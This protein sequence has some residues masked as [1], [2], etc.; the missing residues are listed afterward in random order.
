MRS[1]DGALTERLHEWKPSGKRGA[2]RKRRMWYN[3][4]VSL[5][6]DSSPGRRASGETG[7]VA[8]VAKASPTRRGGN[9]KH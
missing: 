8:G 6:L 2:K 7:D 3:L 9:A 4:S 1:I 5:A